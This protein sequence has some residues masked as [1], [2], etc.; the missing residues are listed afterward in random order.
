MKLYIAYP[1]GVL[2]VRRKWLLTW[3]KVVW[4]SRAGRL[5]WLSLWLAMGLGWKFLCT[6]RGL[7]GLN[8]TKAS[9]E[10]APGIFI[11]LSRCGAP[12]KERGWGLKV[13]SS[14]TS[15]SAVR[16]LITTWQYSEHIYIKFHQDTCDH[17]PDSGGRISW[18]SKPMPGIKTIQRS[19][20]RHYP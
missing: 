18:T 4:E 10:W 9:K 16:L 20:F 1:I 3:F 11:S 6:G 7:H 8:L 13:V 5:A 15:K 17:H 14:Q 19:T 12:R 2:G